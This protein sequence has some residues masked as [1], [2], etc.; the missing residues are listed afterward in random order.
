[1][2]LRKQERFKK[3]LADH[4]TALHVLVVAELIDVLIRRAGI[5]PARIKTAVEQFIEASDSALIALEPELARRAGELRARHYS[6]AKRPLSMTD[7]ALVITASERNLKLVTSDLHLV[8]VAT[9]ED[10]AVEDLS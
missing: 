8:E 4:P 9:A 5:E 7:C 3:L 2:L 10:V 1:M 6:K